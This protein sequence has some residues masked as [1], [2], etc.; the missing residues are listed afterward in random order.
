MITITISIN[1]KELKQVTI[2]NIQTPNQSII[3]T[4]W[5]INTQ[6]IYLKKGDKGYHKKPT[7]PICK[8]PPKIT[9]KTLKFDRIVKQ[10]PL[11]VVQS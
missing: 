5:K 7:K 2:P 8:I 9:S 4:P 1:E 6:R 3:Y 10:E 11:L